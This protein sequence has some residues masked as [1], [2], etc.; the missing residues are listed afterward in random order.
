[1]EEEFDFHLQNEVAENLRR[2]MPKDQA[3]IAA[4]RRFWSGVIRPLRRSSLCVN[5]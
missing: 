3:W 4:R 2:G 1:M 5:A